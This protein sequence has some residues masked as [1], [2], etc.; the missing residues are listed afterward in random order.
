MT[1]TRRIL[2]F[3]AYDLELQINRDEIIDFEEKL[4]CENDF[5]IDI[6]GN[7]YRVIHQ[8]I[9]HDIHK[10]EIKNITEDCYDLDLPSWLVIDWG[11]TSSEVYISYGFGNHFAT[12]DGIE[13]QLD[14]NEKCYYIFRTN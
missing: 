1:N 10:E 7:E 6:D 12:Y 5:N 3:I 9:I 11:A 8:D 2:E 14:Y 4:N 13:M